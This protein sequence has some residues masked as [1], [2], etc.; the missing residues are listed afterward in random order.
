MFESDFIIFS[1]SPSLSLFLPPLVFSGVEVWVMWFVRMFVLCVDSF[2]AWVC[3]CESAHV[4]TL[5]TWGLSI[6]SFGLSYFWYI[7][8][9]S[10]ASWACTK[11]FFF[12]NI[13]KSPTTVSYLFKSFCLCGQNLICFL[14]L[15]CRAPQLCKNFFKNTS[16]RHTCAM[17]DMF[18]HYQEHVAL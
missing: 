7:K 2:C 3:V 14:L 11:L 13:I 9:C 12:T 6:N 17:G 5:H 16:V 8:D 1:L 10:S 4:L 18:L 15:C